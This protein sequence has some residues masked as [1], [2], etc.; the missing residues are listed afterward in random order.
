M[1]PGRIEKDLGGTSNERFLHPE[2][3]Q[4]LDFRHPWRTKLPIPFPMP[5][6]EAPATRIFAAGFQSP[7]EVLHKPQIT[8]APIPDRDRVNLVRESGLHPVSMQ[9]RARAA[10]IYSHCPAEVLDEDLFEPSNWILGGTLLQP[11]DAQVAM[12]QSQNQTMRE[13]VESKLDRLPANPAPDGPSS[14]HWV[15]PTIPPIWPASVEK[16]H[17]CR[18]GGAYRNATERPCMALE[19]LPADGPPPSLFATCFEETLGQKLYLRESILRLGSMVT[20][21]SDRMQV[22]FTSL[23]TGLNTILL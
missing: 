9:G 10:V 11:Q 1:T 16:D 6:Y 23:G 19:Q 12:L 21:R 2:Y 8:A 13:Y 20:D 18:Y 7:M 5:R 14:T 3:T 22:P 4:A 15:L 17:I